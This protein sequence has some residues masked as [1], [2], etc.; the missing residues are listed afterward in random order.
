MHWLSKINYKFVKQIHFLK[1]NNSNVVCQSHGHYY[2]HS[3]EIGVLAVNAKE[4]VTKVEIPNLIVENYQSLPQSGKP[5]QMYELF[6]KI[7]PGGIKLELFGRKNNLKKGWITI[8]MQ[9]Q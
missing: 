9:F 8:G 3:L 5:Q 2:R 1:V 7:A 6:E 4:S